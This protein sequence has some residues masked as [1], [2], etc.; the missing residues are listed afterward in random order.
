MNLNWSL[1]NYLKLYVPFV[2]CIMLYQ[3]V[4]TLNC[5]HWNENHLERYLF[6]LIMLDMVVVGFESLKEILKCDHTYESYVE[7]CPQI[8]LLFIMLFKRLLIE[9]QLFTPWKC[10]WGHS[11]ESYWAVCGTIPQ[12]SNFWVCVWILKCDLS[13]KA[14]E[15]CFVV[16]GYYAILAIKCGS[17]HYRVCRRTERLKLWP[18]L[19]RAM[20][21]KS[22]EQYFPVLP[23]YAAYFTY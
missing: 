12:G 20:I 2:L 19:M 15:Q 7:Y 13:L 9:F 6:L 3:V 14:T 8:A 1:F 23:Y 4:L 16:V 18:F 22:T 10:A 21:M 5:D 17:N 11:N